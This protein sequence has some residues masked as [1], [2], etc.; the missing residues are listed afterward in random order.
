[1]PSALPRLPAPAPAPDQD[2]QE[3][4][5]LGLEAAA[6]ERHATMRTRVAGLLIHLLVLGRLART[7]WADGVD[8]LRLE[9]RSRLTPDLWRELGRLLPALYPEA[10]PH[11]VRKLGRHG[12]DATGLPEACPFTLDQVVGDWWPE[13]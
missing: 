5:R 12:A 4:L 7:G 1:M 3:R 10:V 8:R 9:V 6:R 11:A 2:L 13:P